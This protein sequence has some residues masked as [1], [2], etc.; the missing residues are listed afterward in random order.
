MKT[1]RS[2]QE[3]PMM[4]EEETMDLIMNEILEYHENEIDWW[5]D[6]D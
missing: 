1:K 4:T 2:R 6:D 5:E 3:E